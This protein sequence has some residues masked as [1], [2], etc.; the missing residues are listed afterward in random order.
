[1]VS[2]GILEF[3]ENK[4]DDVEVTAVRLRG[5]VIGE[6]TNIDEAITVVG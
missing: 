5:V 2:Q 3:T 4:W 1:M 6:I